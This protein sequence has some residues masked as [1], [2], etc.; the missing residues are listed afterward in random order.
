MGN[1]DIE[2]LGL[3]A[4]SEYERQNGRT[5]IERVRGCGYDLVSKNQGGTDE[6][7]IEVKATSKDRFT[8][9]W[10][11][12]LEQ[13]ACECDPF[14][15]LYLVTNVESDFPRVFVYDQERLRQRFSEAITH[16]VY[17]FPRAD[18]APL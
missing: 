12:S 7:H 1:I 11:E 16:H 6:R 17:V 3:D 9:R 4:V 8:F 15:F 13:R 14:F 10:L 5:I 2:N 18:F